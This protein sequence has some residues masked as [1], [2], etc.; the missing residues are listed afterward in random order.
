MTKLKCDKFASSLSFF[1]KPA[2]I[3]TALVFTAACAS[4]QKV[5]RVHSS[6]YHQQ[7]SIQQLENDME[8]VEK[9]RQQVNAELQQLQANSSVNEEQI[10][11]TKDQLLELDNRQSD[12][13]QVMRRVNSS[14][15][16]N[17]RSIATINT[18]E[19]KR[20]AII[21]EQ[22]RRWQQITAQTDT[23]LADMEKQPLES[24]LESNPGGS[25]NAQP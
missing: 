8:Q 2:A 1:I 10:R 4:S 6:I 21:K 25:A 15:A 16:S 22:Q 23:K 13:N 7:A 14:V 18:Q 20:Q 11:K 17:S 12:I 24:T 5:D 3:M 19:Q 9:E